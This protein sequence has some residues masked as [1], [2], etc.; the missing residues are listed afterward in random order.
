MAGR[1]LKL[2]PDKLELIK[3]LL[4]EGHFAITVQRAVGISQSA[5]YDYVE[6]GTDL[7]DQL[8]AGDLE[9][10]D[11][12]ENQLL[13]T[14]FVEIIKEAEAI[15]EMKALNTITKASS[16]QWQAAA[17]YLER[18]HRDRWGKDLGD[19]GQGSQNALDKFIDAISKQAD[20][21]LE[22]EEEE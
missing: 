14:E 18:K 1:R 11:L 21:A 8:E 7:L 20:E 16:K 5:W 9:E 4:E 15:A 22:E 12:T 13:M 3:Q 2:T 17:W 10:S 6:K 19:G